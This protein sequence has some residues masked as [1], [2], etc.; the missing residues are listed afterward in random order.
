MKLKEY[1]ENILNILSP[2]SSFVF[3]LEVFMKEGQIYFC[4]IA[5]RP[6][7]ALVPRLIKMS[8]GVDILAEHLRVQVIQDYK[9]KISKKI[10]TDKYIAGYII[11][12]KNGKLIKNCDEIPYEF[13]TYQRNYCKEGST[14]YPNHVGDRHIEVT[15]TA[16]TEKE[17]HKRINLIKDFVKQNS[18]WC[19]R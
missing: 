12:K 19:N 11:P 6:A 16:N 8:Q 17:L 14:Y 3:H 9:P 2:H 10:I 4:E 18:E 7:G 1:T 5:C 13:I 15:L